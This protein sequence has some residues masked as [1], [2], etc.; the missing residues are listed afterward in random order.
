MPTESPN[1]SSVFCALLRRLHLIG[2]RKNH[3]V[4]ALG[5]LLI[6]SGCQS[7]ELKSLEDAS[8][9]FKLSTGSESSRWSQDKGTTLGKPVYPELRIEYKPDAN[10][11]VEDVYQEIINILEKNNWQ[12]E[13]VTIDQPGFYLASLKKDDFVIQ[14]SVL[15]LTE[16]NVVNV[17]LSAKGS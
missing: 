15:I 4:F 16:R 7:A 8:S 5:C 13:K 2:N 12:K 17:Q 1:R 6:L 14:A 11:S 9:V 10:H 3:L